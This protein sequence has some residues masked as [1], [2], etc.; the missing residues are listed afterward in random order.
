MFDTFDLSYFFY[1]PFTS[2]SVLSF[3]LGIYIIR[4]LSFIILVYRNRLEFQSLQRR[5]K[6]FATHLNKHTQLLFFLS[7]YRLFGNV[8]FPCSIFAV[9]LIPL[10]IL[11]HLCLS[12]HVILFS[13]YFLFFYISSSNTLNSGKAI[14]T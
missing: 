6:G 4:L 5:L 2:M 3:S 13:P 12:I 10:F 14:N 11:F 1:F 9:L 7:Q 8:F